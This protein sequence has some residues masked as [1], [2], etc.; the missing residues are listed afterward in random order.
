MK[1]LVNALLGALP[2]IALLAVAFVAAAAVWG[3]DAETTR[4]EDHDGSGDYV[5]ISMAWHDDGEAGTPRLTR[6]TITETNG[7]RYRGTYDDGEVSVRFYEAGSEEHAWSAA[8]Q[9]ALA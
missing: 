8:V 1:H 7:D 2:R 6:F 4:A 3:M 9:P 5:P